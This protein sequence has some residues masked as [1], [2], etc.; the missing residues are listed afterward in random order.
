MLCE[1]DAPLVVVRP[2]ERA[3]V[4][5]GAHPRSRRAGLRRRPRAAGGT[6][7]LSRRPPVAGGRQRARSRRLLG[8]VRRV[9]PRGG[10]RGDARLLRRARDLR[11]SHAQLRLRA[12]AGRRSAQRPLARWAPPRAGDRR[13]PARV[14]PG[15]PGDRRAL[16]RRPRPRARSRCDW[17]RGRL[18]VRP[19]LA[20]G[21][22]PES[23]GEPACPSPRRP[24]GAGRFGRR[25]AR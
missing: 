11:R 19:S 4:S 22:L 7:G 15:P 24:F 16:P 21:H 8:R 12:P 18:E 20:R 6:G 17:L 25:L 14:T 13:A 23:L 2:G 10:R 9:R 3:V 1:W 5:P